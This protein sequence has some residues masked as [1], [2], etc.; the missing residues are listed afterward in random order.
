MYGLIV[1]L[2]SISDRRS[3]LIEVLGG[4]DSRTV[5]GCL[6]FIVAE[7]ASDKDVLWVTE[8]WTNEASHKASLEHP[9]SKP[10][11]PTIEF[12]VASYERIAVTEPVE[13]HSHPMHGELP[14]NDRPL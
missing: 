10:N 3:E 2:T 14:M 9:P 5:A 13:K 12:L 11:L 6:S 4:D 1:K 8:V 7:D